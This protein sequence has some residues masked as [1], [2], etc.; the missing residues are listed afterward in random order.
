M[1]FGHPIAD[2]GHPNINIFGIMQQDKKELGV[3][4]TPNVYFGHRIL[5]V[6]LKPGV[7]SHEKSA[8]PPKASQTCNP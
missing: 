5:K 6:W 8:P 4:F 1:C 2:F 3:Q 7:N